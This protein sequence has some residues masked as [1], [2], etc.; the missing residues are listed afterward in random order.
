MF[1]LRS[2]LAACG[3]FVLVS[4]ASAADLSVPD[5]LPGKY[6]L[7]DW[8]SFFSGGEAASHGWAN[9]YAGVV[10]SP[11]GKIDTSG[12][13]VWLSGEA[14]AYSYG[15]LSEATGLPTTIRG[16]FE[17][18]SLLAGYGFVRNNLELNV[19]TGLNVLSHQLSEPDIGNPVQGTR[20]GL[21]IQEETTYH[22]TPATL[23]Y[24]LA[25]Y[26]TAFQNYYA[27]FKVG[28]DISKGHEVFVGPQITFLGDERFDQWR[29]GLHVTQLTFG[30][31]GIELSGGYV[32]SSDTGSGAYGMIEINFPFH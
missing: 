20:A 12:F 24:S 29:A 1:R 7:G 10:L 5:A 13:R 9:G 16:R 25:S 28:Y 21:Q 23:I 26:S 22:P 18:V 4:S 3:A 17:E 8:G 15:S 31:V 30:K 6:A 14:G 19:Y 27:T 11:F 32:H 2:G